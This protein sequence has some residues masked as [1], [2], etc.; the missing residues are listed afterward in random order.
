MV[1]SCSFFNFTLQ[2]E[3]GKIV[4]IDFKQPKVNLVAPLAESDSEDDVIPPDSISSC[5]LVKL[6]TNEEKRA[7]VC[8][9]KILFPKAA[10]VNVFIGKTTTDS[11]HVA[12]KKLPRTITSFYHP[13]YSNLS[14]QALQR[15]SERVFDE[16]LKV[17]EDESKYL[18]NCTR[19]QSQCTTWFEHRKGRLTASRFGAICHTS[20]NKPSKSLVEQVLQQGRLPKSA[21]LTWGIEKESIARREY[22]KLMKPSHSSFTVETTGLHICPNYPYLG[23]SP[24]GLISCTCCG[25]GILEIKCPYSMRNSIPT[26]VPYLRTSESGKYSL[27]VTHNYYYQVQGQL[28]IVGQQF[29]DFVCWTPNGLYVE[30]IK[31]NP[32][33]FQEMEQKLRKIFIS[34]IFPRV[35]CGNKDLELSHPSEKTGIYCYCRQGE[36]GKMVLCD[37]LD[38]KVGWFHFTCVG[39]TSCP[40]NW[41]CPDCQ[42]ERC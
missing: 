6:P 40:D 28:G 7:Y 23:A 36:L 17:T 37:S 15:E 14:H 21:A 18:A 24:D 16:E 31:F 3:P 2:H 39:I 4:D 38:C 27:A 34:V 10:V 41:F 42:N 20:I 11:G 9:L 30:R 29:C 8:G 26:S 25:R 1:T 35:L 12:T 22:E 5:S 33:F 13:R 19:L 32:D